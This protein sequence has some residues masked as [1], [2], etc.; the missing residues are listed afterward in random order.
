MHSSKAVVAKSRPSARGETGAQRR[1]EAR[2]EG[3]SVVAVVLNGAKADAAADGA[4]AIVVGDAAHVELRVVLDAHAG[5]VERD[6][7]AVGIALDVLDEGGAG[8]VDGA[9]AGR[10][11]DDALPYS[12][13]VRS[14]VPRKSPAAT[15]MVTTPVESACTR[16]PRTVAMAPSD[17]YQPT[18]SVRSIVEPSS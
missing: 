4:R 15:E 11:R 8:S 16:P 14:M 3:A 17:V 10:L 7:E 1:P 18:R 12:V 2:R 6:G 5:R 9:G 13:S